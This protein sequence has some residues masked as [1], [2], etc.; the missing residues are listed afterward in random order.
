MQAKSTTKLNTVIII[1]A[2]CLTMSACSKRIATLIERSK[3]LPYTETITPEEIK[4]LGFKKDQYCTKNKENCVSYYY[5]SPI[6]E[7]KLN[8]SVKFYA[9]DKETTVNLHISREQLKN[10]CK[11]TVILFHGFRGSKEYMLH[12]ALYFRFLGFKV[13]VPDLLGHGESN[14]T[15]KYGVGDS[16]VISQLI[17]KLIEKGD[18]ED[19]NLYL[20][21]SS[22]GALTALYTSTLRSDIT[23]IILLAPMLSF[24]QAF[25]N[26]AKLNHPILSWIIPDKDIRQG[27]NTALERAGVVPNDTNIFP[28]LRASGI[29]ILLISS[30]TDRIA[31]YSSYMTLDQSNIELAEASNRNH[32]SMTTI[33]NIEHKVIINWL[34]KKWDICTTPQNL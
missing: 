6:T 25:H 4:D 11:G 22:M 29:P 20:L 27:A 12:S 34:N 30:P 32:P 5:G 28:L 17:S 8:Y 24:E 26:Y 1:I 33:G 15:K 3:S 9:Q 10:K 2:T 31:P 23:G 14:N 19:K 21:G 16:K 7:S 13:I 18:I